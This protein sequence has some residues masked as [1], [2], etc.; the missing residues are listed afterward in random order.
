MGA[1]DAFAFIAAKKKNRGLNAPIVYGP[2][3]GVFL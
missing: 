2:A 1:Q 3:M